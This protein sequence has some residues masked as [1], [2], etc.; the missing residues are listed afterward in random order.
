M[1]YNKLGKIMQKGRKEKGYTQIVVASLLGVTPQNIS[2]WELGKSK[3]DIDTYIKLCNLY[4]IDFVYSV[5]QC[6]DDPCLPHFPVEIDGN[7]NRT[8]GYVPLAADEKHL[9]SGFRTLNDQGKEY[10]MQTVDMA[11]QV[12]IKSDSAADME[13]KIG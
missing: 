3:M 8:D 7:G 11:K 1:D 6:S 13:N 10:I 9:L 2:S 4:E 12:Y 5:M